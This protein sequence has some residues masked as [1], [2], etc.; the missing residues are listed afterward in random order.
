MDCLELSFP[1]LPQLITVGHAVWTP[2]MSHFVRNFAVYDLIF[3][4]NGTFYICEEGVE[5]TMSEGDV[6]VLEPGKT[7]WGHRAVE[8]ETEVYWVHFAHVPPIRYVE[9][10][11][12]PWQRTVERGTDA[13]LA[14]VPQTMYVPKRANLPTES[15]VP[16]LDEMVRLHRSLTLQ[17][18]LRLQAKLGELLVRLQPEPAAKGSARTMRIAD[19]VIR[20]LQ[21]RVA[22]P[23]DAGAMERAL[24][25]H[26]DYLARC[27]KRHTGMS[28]LRYLH[29]LQIEQAKALLLRTDL[30]VQR[31]GERVGQPNGAYFGRLFR[32]HVGTTPAAY[33]AE[34]KN[35]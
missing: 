27:L 6:L 15:I 13:H 24:H 12:I 26:F 22:E 5:Y 34:H 28:P 3:V 21:E 7:H 14:P 16:L 17:S 11:R 10:E 1:P 25:F 23:F 19:S 9:R 30:P 2:G 31:I 8:E 33:R 32:R 18:S 4:R 20:Y 35:A 29:R